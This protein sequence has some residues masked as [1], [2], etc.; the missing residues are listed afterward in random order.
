MAFLPLFSSDVHGVS[1]VC[2]IGTHLAVLQ[3]PDSPRSQDSH[4][5]RPPWPCG[6]GDRPCY[7]PTPFTACSSLGAPGGAFCAP[8]WS[9]SAKTACSGLF[10]GTPRLEGRTQPHWFH[11]ERGQQGKPVCTLYPFVP[12]PESPKVCHMMSFTVFSYY[13]KQKSDPASGQA[14]K[15]TLPSAGLSPSLPS[16]FF[17]LEYC[18]ANPL[19]PNHPPCR[20]PD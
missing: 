2:W 11:A 12:G 15:H 18:N 6:H 9:E 14:G 4:I 20:D 7:A 19:H 5:L 13:S 17:Y 10:S 1:P 16:L 8:E 3:T